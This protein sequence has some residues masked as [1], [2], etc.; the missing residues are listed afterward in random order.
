MAAAPLRKLVTS[1]KAFVRGCTERMSGIE[2]RLDYGCGEAWLEALEECD[3]L[4]GVA[5]LLLALQWQADTRKAAESEWLKAIVSLT[6]GQLEEEH[7]ELSRRL[8]TAIDQLDAATPPARQPSEMLGEVVLKYFDG[9][10]TYMGTIVEHDELTGFRVQF[11]DGETE[12]YSL[13]DLRALM[14]RS[15]EQVAALE[16]SDAW[17]LGDRK[18]KVQ[19][20]ES[21]DSS[22]SKEG[23]EGK[24]GSE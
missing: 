3:D 4:S 18:A 21:V 12:D 17:M 13:H 11:D 7:A 2:G 9:H 6:A 15:E 14:P 19:H 23:K 24:E 10:G 5:K 1:K 20:E 22:E 8:L 16:A